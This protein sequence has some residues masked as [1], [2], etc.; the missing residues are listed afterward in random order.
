MEEG[1]LVSPSYRGPTF[2]EPIKAF[3]ETPEKEDKD[4]FTF[5]RVRSNT[6]EDFGMK[7]S[8]EETTLG[9]DIADALRFL[10]DIL[11][12]RPSKIGFMCDK[13]RGEMVFTG[14][15][16]LY[17]IFDFGVYFGARRTLVCPKHLDDIKKIC[18]RLK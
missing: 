8:M 15:H 16:L 18:L 3:L 14:T 11:E 7:W 4:L 2:H 10:N 5:S 13:N 17:P 12:S 6:I 9:T 1:V